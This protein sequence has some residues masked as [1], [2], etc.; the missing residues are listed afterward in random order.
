MF[1][2]TGLSKAVEHETRSLPGKFCPM[3]SLPASDASSDSLQQLAG[4][5]NFSSGTSDPS[6][7]A[8]WNHVYAEATQGDPLSGPPPWLVVKDWMTETLETLHADQPAFRDI[9]QANRVVHLLWTELLPAY[10][11]FHRDL[12][13]H[14]EPE[15]LFNGLSLIHI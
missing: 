2:P 4:Y 11:D 13:F 14:Q 10:A 3:S 12:M 8:A 15:L 6:I 9:S 7:L 5:L 1:H